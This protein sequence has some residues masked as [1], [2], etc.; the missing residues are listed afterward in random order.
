MVEKGCVYAVSAGEIGVDCLQRSDV[1]QKV[2]YRGRCP[3]G[4]ESLLLQAL[5]P[6]RLQAASAHDPLE[7][8]RVADLIWCPQAKCHRF[9]PPLCPKRPL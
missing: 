2:T 6:Q 5:R 8:P 3:L 7:Q 9:Q 4:M 1:G